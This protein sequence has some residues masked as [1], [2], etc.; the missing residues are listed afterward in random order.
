M[1]IAA[2]TLINDA[3]GECGVLDPA[4]SMTAEQAAQ[5][6]GVLNRII[7]RWRGQRLYVYAIDD[8]SATFSGATASV[9]AGQTVNTE[10]PI[11][12]EDGCF[13]RIAN[14][15]YPLPQWELTQYNQIALKTTSV[16]SYPQGFYYDRDIPG[17]VTVWPVPAVAIEYH[18]QVMKKLSSFA[19]LDTAYSLPDGYHD[20]LHYTLCERIPTAYNL[21]IN[22]AD[23]AQAA[24][25]RQVIRR[26]NAR[27][28]ILDLAPNQ[29]MRVN[30]FTGLT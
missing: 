1:T 26:A 8:I 29:N 27:V 11:R 3:L 12:F 21:P 30:I 16:S 18:F 22:P 9:G 14:I 13:Y 4:E 24:S 17:T 25:A 23:V 2:R 19:D 5:G 28:P 6:L 20:A 10:S 7:D 15:D